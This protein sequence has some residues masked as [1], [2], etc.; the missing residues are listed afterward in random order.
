MHSSGEVELCRASPLTALIIPMSEI[1]NL[2]ADLSVYY[3]R[4]CAEVDYAE[5]CAFAN[6]AFGCF[7]TSGGRDFLD[8]ACGTG[9]HLRHM[10]DYGFEHDYSV[11]N[12]WGGES[13][14]VIVVASRDDC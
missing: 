7:A 10:G 3:D 11:M 6:R 8:L 2:Y 1:S 13:F 4:F 14:N 5:Q 12:V 9:P